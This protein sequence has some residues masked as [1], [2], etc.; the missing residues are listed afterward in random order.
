MPHPETESGKQNHPNPDTVTV[1]YVT[2]IAG[3]VLTVLIVVLYG[4]LNREGA[5]IEGMMAI[6]AAGIAL[7]ALI[8][9]AMNVHLVSAN[10][11][12]TIEIQ[13]QATEIQKEAKQLQQLA[14][15]FQH[16]EKIARKKVYASNLVMQW[17]DP[18]TTK[19]TVVAQALD[20]EVMDLKPGEVADFLQE[21][22]EK[23]IAVFR[24]LNFLENMALSIKHDL[25]DEQFLKEYFHD[26]LKVHYF[27]LQTFIQSEINTRKTLNV[28]PEFR[29]L[30]ERWR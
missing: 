30:V 26:I 27:I 7:T 10:Q 19:L 2:L 3:I 28:Y 18:E 13:K 8:Y 6:A 4:L 15:E 20:K 1:K 24:V 11:R 21:N 29:A 25:A 22:K 17:N 12:Q 23:Q 14:M 5:K 9:T 16:N